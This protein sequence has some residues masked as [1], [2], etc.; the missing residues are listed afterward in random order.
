MEDLDY[1][2]ANPQASS[3]IHSLRAFGYDLPAAA[4]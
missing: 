4:V 3:L 2:L 1:D